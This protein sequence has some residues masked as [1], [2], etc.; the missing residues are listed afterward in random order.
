VQLCIFLWD[1]L[2]SRLTASFALRLTRFVLHIVRGLA[3]CALIFPFC[4]AER[5]HWHVQHWSRRLLEICGVRC[6]HVNAGPIGKHAMVVANHVSWLDIFVINALHPCRFIAKSEVRGW[7]VLGWLAERG[8]TLFLKR[9]NRRDLQ[10]VLR[11]VV[12][13]L[14]SGERVAYFPEGTSSPHGSLLS[15]HSALFEAALEADVVVQPYAL[16]YVDAT[17]GVHRGA[18]YVGETT[19]AQS[20]ARILSGE[21]IIAR[22]ERLPPIAGAGLH[23]RVLAQSA[24]GA[25]ESA[26]K[27]APVSL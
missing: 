25:V 20:V 6:E 15:F 2:E 16:R 27:R 14:R 17:G 5:R 26:L 24:H 23:R 1:I 3:I 21:A 9:A 13:H 12:D 8:G 19:F 4:K 10:Q 11:S 22:L 7:P 18:E